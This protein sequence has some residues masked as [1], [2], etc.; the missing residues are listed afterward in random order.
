MPS[1]EGDSV[2]A[3]MYG[4]NFG[5]VSGESLESAPGA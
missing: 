5:P 2:H 4:S 1:G 3:A